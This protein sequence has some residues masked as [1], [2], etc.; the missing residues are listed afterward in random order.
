MTLWRVEWIRLVRTR[1]WIALAGVFLFFGL[2]GPLTARYLAEIVGF[3]GAELEGATIEFP[4][5]VPADGM[6]QYV[7]NAM[8]IGTLVAVVVAA[9]SLAFD[10][11]PEMGVFLR[12]RI[13]DVRTILTPRVAVTT[14][15]VVASF[16]IG[17]LAAWYETWAL[18]GAP[19]AGAVGAGI[20]YGALFLVFVVA[21]VAAVAGRASSVIGTVMT[22][23]VILLVMPILGIVE[24]IGRWLPSHLGGALGALPAG[25]ADA[26][27]YLA[28][29]GV[30]V[31]A[32]AGLLWLAVR[33]A[34][35]REL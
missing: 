21:L 16:V 24:A 2:L 4:P 11:I 35:R 9:G 18:I 1:R 10:A 7:S 8:Q 28:A 20:L 3:A 6:A 27:D 12:T 13:P 22:S 34:E 15:S 32:T 33:L 30:T 26:G 19:D 25:S 31:V 23:I 14:S 17:A 29:A 5:P